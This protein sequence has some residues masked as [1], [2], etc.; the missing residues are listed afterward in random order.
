MRLQTLRGVGVIA[1]LAATI[2]LAGC[3]GGGSSGGG[4]GV[5]GVFRV[6]AVAA[7]PNGAM[8]PA[9][10]SPS[11]ENQFLRIEFSDAVD[12]ATLFDATTSNGVS[13]ALRL[14]NRYYLGQFSQTNPPGAA[15]QQSSRRLQGVL[16][17]NG[18]TNFDPS[19]ST[20]GGVLRSVTATELGIAPAKYQVAANVA[21]FIADTDGALGTPESFLPSDL[22][23][24]ALPHAQIQVD[25]QAGVKSAAG[26]EALSSR[27]A[28][29]FNVGDR[30]YV[31]PLIDSVTP[32]NDQ[33][34]VDI[35]SD[36]VIRLTEP[37]E[38]SSVISA[39]LLPTT[40]PPPPYSLLVQALSTGPN[41]PQTVQLVGSV[42]PTSGLTNELRFTPQ[43]DLPGST[44]IRVTIVSGAP[45][46][47]DRAN[48]ELPASAFT[49]GAY[50]FTTGRGPDLANNP[51]AP[52]VVHFVTTNSEIG[53]INVVDTDGAQN[54]DFIVPVN[55][56]ND[57]ARLVQ[58]GL[59]DVVI[60]PF[61]APY[62]NPPG[63]GNVIGN[64]PVPNPPRITTTP[65]PPITEYSLPGAAPTAGLCGTLPVPVQA[66]GNFLFV[67][68]E[69]RNVIHVFNSNT[70]QLYKDI[71]APDPRRIAIDP[72]LQFM[73][74]SNF[75]GNSVSV[76]DITAD[77]MTSLPRGSLVRTIPTG[78]GADALTVGPDNED[79]FVVNRLENSVSVIQLNQVASNDPV[80]LTLRGNVGPNCVDVCATGRIPPLLPSLS[81]FPN[82]AYFANQG[83]DSVSVFESGPQQVNGYGRDNIV[84]V[85]GQLPGPTSVNADERSGG[86]GSGSH[87]PIPPSSSLTG[88]WVTCD[89]GT[90]R[91]LRATRFRY[92][93][94][95]NPPPSF[96]GVDFETT[97]VVTVG[98]RPR[99]VVLRDPYVTCQSN[100]FKHMPDVPNAS[101]TSAP[102]R[103]YVANGDGTVSVIDLALGR[104][105]MRLQGAG[106]KKM[107]A[108]YTN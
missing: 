64:P 96:V 2:G 29:S 78:Q 85:L 97:T 82:Y 60:G 14:I 25:V 4:T 13:S 6:I 12:P 27:F 71:P 39:P 53:A 76:F 91:Y 44:L 90:A 62:L 43:V 77:P 3:G 107:A 88:F 21:Y 108:F 33:T 52:G 32:A 58:G 100:N 105:L 93:P 81:P 86:V 72:L 57:L 59:S 65:A 63:S 38:A 47:L 5:G 106:V 23:N 50:S 45:Y 22:F 24:A 46:H 31:Y 1:G 10:P 83:A 56:R 30:D 34:N 84:Q 94:F 99:D 95:P 87:D 35:K 75:G 26:G 73:F 61:I 48:N 80:R 70:Y 36:I 18:R 19:T 69:D 74:V 15:S 68:N 8:L 67:A 9:Q 92:S 37:I 17:L 98:A 41:G 101:Q 103:M 102:A 66:I 40:G 54:E 49:D 89:D 51:V 11:T 7:E 42:A 55:D 79:L 20:Y 28:A 104:E 16:V